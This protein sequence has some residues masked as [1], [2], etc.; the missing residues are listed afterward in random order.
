MRQGDTTIDIAA[1]EPRQ[2]I[3]LRRHVIGYVSQFL[4][5]LPRVATIDVVAEPLVIVGV[6]RDEARY[7]AANLL[8]CVN[9]P[10]R[11]FGLSPAT[12]SGGE[13]Q[14]VNI[15]RGFLPDVPILLL[16]EPT[17][18]LDVTNRTA[19]VE[20]DC[21]KEAARRSD[22]RCCSRR[23][24]PH[25]HRR[26]CHRRYAVCRRGLRTP[27]NSKPSE[28]ILSNARVVLADHVI[29]M[30]WVVVVDGAIVEIGEGRSSGV[31]VR[32]SPAIC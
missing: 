28:L 27:M 7:R 4:R 26:H 1:A 19:V 11:L 15:A 25:H 14:R 21:R 5:A 24:G 17:A 23:R 32:I 20:V 31:T 29:E 9:I 16:D 8:R 10:E 13:Q 6:P 12:F 18:S 3:A 22:P 2:I 30:G